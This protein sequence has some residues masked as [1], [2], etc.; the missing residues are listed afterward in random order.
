MRKKSEKYVG[1][2][3]EIDGGMTATGRIIR[4]AWAF[5]LIPESETCEGWMPQGLED[6]WIKVNTEW[7]KYG[8]L[9]GNLPEDIRERYMRISDAAV[10]RAR[11][12][13]WDPGLDNN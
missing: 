10:K 1:I 8:F 5:G 4:D 6:L 2:D 9:V 12:E 13:G 7:E 11:E 3:K